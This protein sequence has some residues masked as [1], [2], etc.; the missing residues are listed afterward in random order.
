M[1][2]IYKGVLCMILLTILSTFW[3]CSNKKNAEIEEENGIEAN[4][5]AFEKNIKEIYINMEY[6]D[7]EIRSAND[8][9]LE[10]KEDE[11]FIECDTGEKVPE[12]LINKKSDVLRIEETEKLGIKNKESYTIYLYLPE[13]SECN[14]ITINS[15]NSNVLLEGMLNVKKMYVYLNVAQNVY[16]S[17]AMINDLEIFT[18]AGDV[19]VQLKG[20]PL[21]YNYDLSTNQ[22][23]IVLNGINYTEISNDIIQENAGVKTIKVSALGDVRVEV[24]E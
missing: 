8:N 18:L 22:G 10:L 15:E 5:I 24:E 19:S 13:N 3:G 1:K 12:I 2:K 11:I 23:E 14:S 20:D 17:N 6:G 21:E 7:I 16:I 9:N 4:Q